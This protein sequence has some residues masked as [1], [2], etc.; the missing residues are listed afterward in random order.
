LCCFGVLAGAHSKEERA[1]NQ[2]GQV[3]QGRGA[4][5]GAAS[6][7]GQELE[8][9][10]KE[11]GGDCLL[12]RRGR[13]SIVECLQQCSDGGEKLGAPFDVDGTPLEVTPKRR[14]QIA[15][16]VSDS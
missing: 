5:V 16:G 11:L 7:A 6:A 12:S 9:L 14:S 2:V 3:S 4:M 15:C 10:P 13:V 8:E 1:D